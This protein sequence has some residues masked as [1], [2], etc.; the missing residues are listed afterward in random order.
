[1]WFFSD[2]FAFDS[3]QLGFQVYL[4]LLRYWV[5]DELTTCTW[6]WSGLGKIE[7]RSFRKTLILLRQA[8]KTKTDSLHIWARM[9]FVWDCQKQH[10]QD[11][12]LLFDSSNPEFSCFFF[13]VSAQTGCLA[14][15][16]TI[17]CSPPSEVSHKST[18]QWRHSFSFKRKT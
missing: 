4:I 14:G 9:S 2:P 12:T 16:R 18:L 7:M 6:R 5:K 3:G 17:L 11:D 10:N 13:L 15:K 1:M 8:K